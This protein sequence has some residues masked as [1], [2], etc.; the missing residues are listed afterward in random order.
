MKIRRAVEIDHCIIFSHDLSFRHLIDTF[1]FDYMKGAFYGSN[2]NGVG[3]LSERNPRYALAEPTDR[4]GSEGLWLRHGR[5]DRR[6]HSVLYLRYHKNHGSLG[7]SDFDYCIHSKLFSAGEDQKNTWPVS[8]DLGKYTCR[9]TRNGHT[10]LFLLVDSVVYWLHK[11]RA[12]AGSNLL[13]PDFFSDGRLGKPSTV[14]E[15]FRVEGRFRVCDTW[16][17]HCSCRRYAD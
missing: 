16:T 14:D 12:I 5:Q 4:Y 17:G 15:Y 7:H 11:R 8:R 10:V 9:L 13:F 6:Q 3:F 2:K 1:Q